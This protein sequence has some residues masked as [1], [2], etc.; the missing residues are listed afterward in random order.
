MLAVIGSVTT[1]ARFAK[2]M[3]SYTGVPALVVDTPQE[4]RT[5]GCSYAVKFRDRYA[6]TA[7]RAAA[8][9]RIP[10]K[11]FYYENGEHAY[12]AVP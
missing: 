9:Y 4:L 11:G 2:I 8:E 1:A 6:D 3:E 10:V 5:G 7:E 12:N